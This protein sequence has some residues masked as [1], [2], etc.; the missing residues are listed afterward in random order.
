MAADTVATTTDQ[1][2]SSSDLSWTSVVVALT[3]L[4][5]LLVG[6]LIA[7]TTTGV[8]GLDS[9]GPTSPRG[10]GSVAVVLASPDS[11]STGPSFGSAHAVRETFDDLKIASSLPAPWV[12]TGSGTAGVVA[13][14]TSVDRSFR[15]RS[16]GASPTRAC[17]PLPTPTAG[18]LQLE[19]DIQLDV[20]V[21]ATSKLVTIESAAGEALSISID[22]DGHF[23]GPDGQPAA[24]GT[25]LRPGTWAHIVIALYR[26]TSTVDWQVAAEDGTVLAQLAHSAVRGAS[27]QTAD[28]V[29]LISPTG[30]AGASVAINNLVVTG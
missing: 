2:S 4:A 19:L 11:P 10:S 25:A 1:G 22:A 15:L 28:S 9:G 17:R 12:V 13:L 5:G 8:L 6:A 30:T 27:A 14:P 29:C 18:D 16:D 23:L 21:D 7:L 24:G 3:A 20:A 26:S